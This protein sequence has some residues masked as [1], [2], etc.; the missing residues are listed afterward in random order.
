MCVV[1]GERAG[2]VSSSVEVDGGVGGDEEGVFL[3]VVTWGVVAELPSLPA[4][5]ALCLLSGDGWLG[6]EEEEVGGDV[7]VELH[8]EVL[9]LE[10]GELQRAVVERVGD[11][12]SVVGSYACVV[13]CAAALDNADVDVAGEVEEGV[14]NF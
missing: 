4:C 11:D 2:E 3:V 6:G 1:D 13:E 14:G 9:W 5:L 7:S 8:A 10:E 12:S